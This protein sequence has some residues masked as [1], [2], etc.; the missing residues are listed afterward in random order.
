MSMRS[1]EPLQRARRT[2][3][4][5]TAR[6]GAAAA[7]LCVA[8]SLG[9]CSE[10]PEARRATPLPAVPGLRADGVPLDGGPG[11][12]SASGGSEGRSV[13]A[14][15]FGP[16]LAEVPERARGEIVAALGLVADPERSTLLD[17]VC[18]EPVRAVVELR[19]L[20]DDGRTEVMVVVESL[21]L[22]GG[23]GAG[24]TLFVLDGEGSYRPNLGFPGYVVDV[25]EHRRGGFPDLLVGGASDCFAV[26]GWTG[27]AYDHVRNEPQSAGACDLLPR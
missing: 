16:A 4:N 8:L 20:N 21:C 15:L 27:R 9:A 6:P 25:L 24:T 23:T 11:G 12:G 18:G 7:V 17:D 10:Q 19:D 13:A 5:P 2:S 22:Y 26:W 3:W 1:N 14:L